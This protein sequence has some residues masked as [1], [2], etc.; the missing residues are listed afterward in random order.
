MNYLDIS[1]VRSVSLSQNIS[2]VE[3]FC[4]KLT[5]NVFSVWKYNQS[6]KSIH[7]QYILSNTK[8]HIYGNTTNIQR[9]QKRK[10]TNFKLNVK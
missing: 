2:F 5:N 6:D 9:R 4:G 3:M 8:C 7:L 1:S 10:V